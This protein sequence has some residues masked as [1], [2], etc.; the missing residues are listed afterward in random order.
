MACEIFLSSSNDDWVESALLSSLLNQDDSALSMQSS[1]YASHQC[2]IDIGGLDE[3]V[4]MQAQLSGSPLESIE[5][6][7]A[8]YSPSWAP[9][10][11]DDGASGSGFG[12]GF[13]DALKDDV[14]VFGPS[15]SFNEM[16]LTKSI[17]KMSSSSYSSN[18]SSYR[19]VSP[20]PLHGANWRLPPPPSSRLETRLLDA[21]VLVMA[22]TFACQDDNYQV[23]LL[24]Y[25]RMFWFLFLLF[26]WLLSSSF[27][28]C[29][30]FLLSPCCIG[31]FGGCI[32]GIT[33]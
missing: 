13:G 22:T 8:V 4:A 24:V 31:L 9:H 12:G 2:S 7:L 16:S 20:T 21:S 6:E 32:L 19:Q 5:R 18:S 28:A 23:R 11:V 26:N 30:W 25:T 29:V 27:P 14:G 10:H 17:E 1:N 3:L 15:F 33:Q